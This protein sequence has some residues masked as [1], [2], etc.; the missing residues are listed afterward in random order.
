[1]P[2]TFFL[3]KDDSF[4]HNRNRQGDWLRWNDF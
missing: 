2:F 4:A 1:M 3:K